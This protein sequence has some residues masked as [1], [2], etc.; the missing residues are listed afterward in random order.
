MNNDDNKPNKKG[1]GIAIVVLLL[2]LAVGGY[3]AFSG[4]FFSATVNPSDTPDISPGD[5]VSDIDPLTGVPE[6]GEW[7]FQLDIGNPGSASVASSADGSY[8]SMAVDGQNLLFY[9]TSSTPPY[10]YRTNER[11]FELQEPDG[12][13]DTGYAYY[14]FVAVDSDVIDGVLYHD[15]D[16]LGVVARDF[17]MELVTPDLPDTDQYDLTTGAW[18]V[19][20]HDVESDCDATPVVASFPDLPTEMN[21]QYELDLDTGGDTENLQLTLDGDIMLLDGSGSV[22]SYG[23]TGDTIEAGTPMDEAGDVLFDY[24]DDTFNAEYNAFATGPDSMEGYVEITGSNGCTYT[25]GYS[26]T[27][28]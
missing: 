14:E 11:S 21:V 19:E 16:V 17:H 12:G 27:T 7:S 2:L 22:N 23:S 1:L 13:T 15:T 18:N 5:I 10:T 6:S 20:Y 9:T 4:S 3:A 24:Q 26:G 28:G 25:V 8:V